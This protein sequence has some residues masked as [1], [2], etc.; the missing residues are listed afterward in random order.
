M[1][2]FHEIC[3]QYLGDYKFL[4]KTYI[5]AGT[6][7]PLPISILLINKYICLG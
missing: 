5:P 3:I 2:I 7:L 4:L 6:L 1:V